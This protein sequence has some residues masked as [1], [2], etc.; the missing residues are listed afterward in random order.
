MI[1]C[2][3]FI[4]IERLHCSFTYFQG[5]IQGGL[6]NQRRSRPTV[7]VHYGCAVDGRSQLASR[8]WSRWAT[9]PRGIERYGSA[10]FA[11]YHLKTSE[12]RDNE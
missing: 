7:A 8:D 11:L 5:E 3:Q 2:E 4:S 10:H 12:R 9:G 6:V 1:S